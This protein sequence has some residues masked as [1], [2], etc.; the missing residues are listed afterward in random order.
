MSSF[1][2]MDAPPVPGSS[3]SSRASATIHWYLLGLQA[4]LFGFKARLHHLVGRHAPV[5]ILS[6]DILEPD[7]SNDA[8]GAM[9][10][11]CK[12]H[13]DPATGRLLG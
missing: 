7:T 8:V 12:R 4:D 5:M 10:W 11:I 3:R 6:W 1:T 13:L 9:C 2:R